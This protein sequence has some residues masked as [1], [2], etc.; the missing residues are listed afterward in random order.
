MPN[1]PEDHP[2]FLRAYEQAIEGAPSP[3]IVKNKKGTLGAV[4]G[5][6]MQSQRRLAYAHRSQK[7]MAYSIHKLLKKRGHN[8]NI[9]VGELMAASLT[10]AHLRRDIEPMTH[11]QAENRLKAWRALL[12]QAVEMGL[13][14]RNVARDVKKPRRTRSGN[15]GFPA[16]Q[17]EYIGAFRAYWP[18]GSEQRLLMELTYWTAARRGDVSCFGPGDLTADGWISFVQQKTQGTV[19]VPF[20]ALPPG[21]EA[22]AEDHAHVLSALAHADGRRTWVVDA[23]GQPRNARTMTGFFKRSIDAV[24]GL[25][26]LGLGFHGLRK[27]RARM[28]IE[29]GWE[30]ARIAAWTGHQTLQEVDHYSR[31]RSKRRLLIGTSE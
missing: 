12:D 6:F 15:E 24:P 31:S 29:L 22:L 2:K 16:W 7:Q 19:E 28:L 25:A 23:D 4:A 1:L 18:Y 3:E 14:D 8:G 30:T 13:V 9:T 21:W 26:G 20:R 27:A 11:G 10:A 17:P 5:S